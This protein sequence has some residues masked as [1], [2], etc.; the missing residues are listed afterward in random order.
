[1]KTPE[2]TVL[3]EGPQRVELME[4]LYNRYGAGKRGSWRIM[5]QHS[6]LEKEICL[7]NCGRRLKTAK[8]DHRHCRL[9]I[10]DALPLAHLSR[11]G[12]V[13]KTHRRGSPVVLAN[14][15]RTLGKRIPLSQIQVHG[16]KRRS[17]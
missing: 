7:D 9:R 3:K 11:G 8:T 15:Y 12:S 10:I 13:H 4:E 6:I 1:M 2:K 17:A 5:G 14:T 16:S